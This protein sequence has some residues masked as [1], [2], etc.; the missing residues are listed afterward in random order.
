LEKKIPHESE[1]REELTVETARQNR[2]EGDGWWRERDVGVIG[3]SAV[4]QLDR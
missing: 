4:G 2:R 3:K 1:Q